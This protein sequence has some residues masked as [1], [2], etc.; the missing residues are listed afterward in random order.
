MDNCVL[1]Y[2]DGWVQKRIIN[3]MTSSYKR[4]IYVAISRICIIYLKN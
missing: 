2:M 4:P 3:P 1:F